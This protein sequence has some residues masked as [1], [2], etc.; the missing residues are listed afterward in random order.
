MQALIQTIQLLIKLHLS[1]LQLAKQKTELVKQ[2]DIQQLTQLLKDEQRHVAAIQQQ[3]K[4][5]QTQAHQLTQK[6]AATISDCLHIANE[7][8]KA[9]L[10]AL[11]EELLQLITE[12]KDINHLNQQMLHQSLQYVNMSLS[13]MT[14]QEQN[15]T[16]NNP[17]NKKTT[18]KSNRTLF[19]SQ[20]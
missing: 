3:E 19:D 12:L 18:Q 1:L 9:T 17:A 5:R 6:E 2:N 16:Y 20:A 10:Q 14:P 15:V 13:V 7:T 4:L 11:Q 8:D